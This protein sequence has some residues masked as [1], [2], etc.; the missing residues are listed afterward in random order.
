VS[1][2]ENDGSLIVANAC[3]DPAEAVLP[4]PNLKEESAERAWHRL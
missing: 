2:R 3:I 1:N 4:L